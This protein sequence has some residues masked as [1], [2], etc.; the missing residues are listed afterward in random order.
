MRKIIAVINS[1]LDGFCD[2]TAIS[3]DEQIH[4]HYRRL[5][6]NSDA[7]LYGRITFDLMKFWPPLLEKPSG[8]KAMDDFAVA[9]DKIPKIVFSNT[10]R[11]TQWESAKI[12]NRPIDA[13]VS[14]FKKQ[15]GRDILVGSRS[16]IVQLTNLNLIDEY[17]ICVHP[18]A[19]G[20]GLPLFEN[21]SEPVSFRL[22]KTTT[23]ESGAVLFY[24]NRD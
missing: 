10:I 11:D 16:L 3:P 17:Q 4:E 22:L 6:L 21:L 20:K 8:D 2:H 12:D 15:T 1:T 18:V 24:Y 19:A 9:I 23:F 14:D 13:V 5:L 7:I